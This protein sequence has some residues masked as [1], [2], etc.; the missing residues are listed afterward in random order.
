V[1]LAWFVP[2]LRRRLGGV[3]GDC[4]G[5]ACYAGQLLVLLAASVLPSSG[6]G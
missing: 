4:L 3:T 5:A 6:T 1:F 2:Y